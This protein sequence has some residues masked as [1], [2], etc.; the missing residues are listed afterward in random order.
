[1]TKDYVAAEISRRRSEARQRRIRRVLDFIL[2]AATVL[3]VEGILLSLC[4]M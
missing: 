4:F 2:S 1:M 3:L